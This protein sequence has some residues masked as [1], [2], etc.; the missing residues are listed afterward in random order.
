MAVCYD[1]GVMLGADTRTSSGV[2]V[3]NRTSDKIWPIA[4]NIF[5]LK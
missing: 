2:F 4:Q 5:S 1:K 3:A